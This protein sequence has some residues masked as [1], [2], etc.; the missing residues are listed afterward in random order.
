[1]HVLITGGDGFVACALQQRLLAEGV[2]GQKLT[3][4]TLIDRRFAAEPA[5]SAVHQIIG[6]IT[7]PAILEQ[8][9]A[10]PVDIL[11]HL[12]SLPGGAAEKDFAA[13]LEVNL[14]ATLGLLE[15][16]RKQAQQHAHAPM[17]VF[18]S[19]I[20]VYGEPG[21]Q[22]I[23]DATPMQPHL[24]YGAHKLASEILIKD[25]SR[26]GWVDGRILR[27]PGIVARPPTPSGLL[28]AFMSEVFWRLAAGERFVCP[29]SREATAW[30]MSVHCC[31]DNLLHAT[32]L[33]QEQLAQRRDYALPVLHL[34]MA[35]LIDALAQTYG[36][37]RLALVEY[38]PNAQLEA[39][40]GRQPPLD[41][42][43][44][45]AAGFTHDGSVAQLIRN[46]ITGAGARGA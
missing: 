2:A 46:A 26:R 22:T 5:A 45:Q 39:G 32:T 24:S 4:L 42:R 20:A 10:Q 16:A 40:F 14:G 15:Q 23:D 9:F 11:F 33:S 38:A 3:R 43:T 37:D 8:A 18:S 36:T 12:A 7:D 1:M 44:A 30:W 25:Y 17:M 34:S 29:V 35:Q 31:V 19:S 6:S 13:G 41:A 21:Q 27:L 28:S